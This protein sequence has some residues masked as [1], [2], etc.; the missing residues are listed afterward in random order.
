MYF[1]RYARKD[2]PLRRGFRFLLS[3]FASDMVASLKAAAVG[4]EHRSSD[5][6][7]ALKT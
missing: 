1:S 6:Y 2:K 5:Y 4:L 7:D 3:A